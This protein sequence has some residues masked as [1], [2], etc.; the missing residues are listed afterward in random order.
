MFRAIRNITHDFQRGAGCAKI[1]LQLTQLR[2][3]VFISELSEVPVTHMPKLCCS[4]YSFG[5]IQ[6]I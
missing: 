3:T 2:I 5:F 4:L 6:I 1:S